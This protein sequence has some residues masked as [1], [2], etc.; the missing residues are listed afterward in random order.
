[1]ADYVYLKFPPLY[2]GL[3]RQL[4]RGNFIPKHVLSVLLKYDSALHSIYSGEKISDLSYHCF[5][6]S[7]LYTAFSATKSCILFSS[8]FPTEVTTTSK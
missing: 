3:L 6:L 7:F 5:R 2:P 8:I 4:C 1:M